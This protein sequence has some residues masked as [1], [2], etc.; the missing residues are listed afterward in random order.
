M[1]AATTHAEFAKTVYAA[2]AEE[3]KQKITSLPMFYLG[4]QGP[5]LFFFHKYMFLPNSLNQYGGM[6]HADKVKETIAYM[7][8]HTHSPSLHSYYC[9]FL[10]HY[11]LDSSC[12]PIINAYSRMEF[13]LNGTNESEAH[14]R[15]EGEV[16][17]WLLHQL[18]RSVK[19][20]NVY[21]MLKIS[22]QE[23][24][25]L[26]RMYHGLFQEVYAL[27]I[28]N[29]DIEAACYDCMRITKQLRPSAGKHK[30]ARAV[31]NLAR[32][33]HL[34]T[35]MML[36]DKEDAHPSVLNP[37]HDLWVWYGESRKTFPELMD[38]A[39]EYALKLIPDADPALIK[40]NFNGVPLGE[41]IL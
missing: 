21:N 4:S 34:I 26:G 18:E 9:G 27:N 11:A 14:F 33:P 19:D 5:D 15:L 31:E 25:E 13:E 7:K 40:K 1:P 8:A 38:E 10:T 35:G 36:T 23:V 17:G 32:M 16:D 41:T 20:Y 12:H 39:R 6:M 37:N 3:E 2:M 24:K 29:K 22:D 28:A 30:L